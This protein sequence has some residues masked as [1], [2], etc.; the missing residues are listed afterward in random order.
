[1]RPFLTIVQT[2]PPQPDKQLR[3]SPIRT[4]G[5]AVDVSDDVSVS[6][7]I[8]CIFSNMLSSVALLSAASA[9]ATARRNTAT[10][11]Q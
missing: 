9:A 2:I 5:I 4:V 11:G 7:S 3:H 8:Y 6:P 10:Y 1:M